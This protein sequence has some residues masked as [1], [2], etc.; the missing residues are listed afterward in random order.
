MVRLLLHCCCGPCATVVAEHFRREGEEVVG[1]FFNP[2]IHPEEEWV[3]R[4]EALAQAASRMGLP[5]LASGPGM[6]FDEFLLAMAR[7]VGRRCLACYELRLRATAREAAK[8]GF[9][10]FSTTLLI[11][12]YQEVEAIGEI[13][14]KAGAEFGVGFR[15][16]DLRGRYGE[17]TERARELGL[18]R[19]NYCGCIFSALE[20]AERRA[21][22]A[23]G[24]SSVVSRKP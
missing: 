24:K 3:R 23:I 7:Q 2:N 11:S 4:E 1:W 8:R 13:G 9:D 20:R 12:P 10:G 22:R 16:A 15:Y 18:Y 6:G 21:R 5:L 17:S 14:R 19:Q